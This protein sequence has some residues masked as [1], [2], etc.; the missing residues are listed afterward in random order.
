LTS[1]TSRLLASIHRVS[2]VIPV[3]RDAERAIELVHALQKQQLPSDVSVEIIVVDDGSSDGSADHLNK[4]LR[5]QV[6]LQRLAINSGRAIARNVGASI[7][8][9]DVL[10]FIDCD[11]LPADDTLIA[12]HLSVWSGNVAATIGPVTGNGDCF[13]NR[14]QSAASERRARQHAAGLYF[15]GSSQNLMVSRAAFRSCGGFDDSYRTYGFED[16][17]L[18][19]RIARF[20]RIC[21][22]A[23][24]R[25]QHM[26]EL[27]LPLVCLKMAEAGGLSAILF[28]SRYPEAYKALGYAA[29]DARLHR[30]LCLP[31]RL[32][33]GVITPFAKIGNRLIENP[34]VPYGLKSW[35]VKAMTGISY[36]IGT[37]RMNQPD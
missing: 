26:D 35:L 25:V 3:Y 12:A 30:W 7:A 16:R 24:A 13:W 1:A 5:D 6:L 22:A 36:L 21:W 33:D 20:G 2:V 32:L 10:L 23:G 31:A 11:C 34:R 9:G 4:S 15:S 18:Q 27:T 17:D 14:Y 37:N 19:L 28:S 8:R 29:L